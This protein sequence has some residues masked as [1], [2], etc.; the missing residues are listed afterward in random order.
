VIEN[1]EQFKNKKT[2]I[3]IS[4]GNIDDELFNK[5]TKASKSCQ[6]FFDGKRKYS[7]F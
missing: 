2:V 4:G 7:F 3:I 5:I 1:K 6:K